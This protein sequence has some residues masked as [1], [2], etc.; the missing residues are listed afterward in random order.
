MTQ[1]VIF[2]ALAW[3]DGDFPSITKTTDTD[4][5][6]QAQEYEADYE[7]PEDPDAI[8]GLPASAAGL[9]DKPYD[10]GFNCDQQDAGYGYYAD[11]LNDCKV[12][13]MRE[14]TIFGGEGV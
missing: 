3:Y 9:L 7:Y 8:E 1:N 6:S 11:A 14:H 12:M 13:D 2:H 10:D 4:P 5:C